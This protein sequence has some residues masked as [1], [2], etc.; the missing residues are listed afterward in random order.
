MSPTTKPP[1]V[2]VVEDEALVRMDTS[3]FLT[4]AGYRVIA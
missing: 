2:L 4:N 3:D 1:V